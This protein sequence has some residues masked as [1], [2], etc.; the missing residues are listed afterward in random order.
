MKKLL[1]AFVISLCFVCIFGFITTE[2]LAEEADYVYI[3]KA[4]D[5]LPTA[6]E[7]TAM[8]DSSKQH[9]Y[10]EAQSIADLYENLSA[11]EVELVNA[12]KLFTLMELFAQAVEPTGV[13]SYGFLFDQTLVTSE[14][15][16]GRGWSYD[17][18]TS[19]LTLGDERG[20]PI[21]FGNVPEN[22]DNIWKTQWKKLDIS[23]LETNEFELG[24][25]A[26]IQPQVV[27][28]LDHENE[29]WEFSS[30]KPK[31]L[32]IEIK[33]TVSLGSEAWI[34]NFAVYS[35]DCKQYF[36]MGG[37]I[38]D[39]ELEIKGNGTLKIYS[40]TY[41]IFNNSIKKGT[42]INGIN[43]IAESYNNVITNNQWLYINDSTVNIKMHSAGSVCEDFKRKDV[44]GK[45]LNI[46]DSTS[47]VT[48]SS[49]YSGLSIKNSDVKIE[50]IWN[51]TICPEK[52]QY[53]T[54]L[55]IPRIYVTNSNLNVF[56]YVDGD[57]QGGNQPY[58]GAISGTIELYND[59]FVNSI[60]DTKTTL[61]NRTKLKDATFYGIDGKCVGCGTATLI[62]EGNIDAGLR[63]QGIMWFTWDEDSN[64]WNNDEVFT[65]LGVNMSIFA[66]Y[67]LDYKDSRVII[68][69]RAINTLYL[70]E[71]NG[72]KQASWNN[73]FNSCVD[74][75]D[76]VIDESISAVT[77]ENPCNIRVLSGDF[78]FIPRA[79]NTVTQFYESIGGHLTVQLKDGVNYGDISVITDPS[80]SVTIQ[81]NG[82]VE[83]LYAKPRIR[84]NQYTYFL[85]AGT[86]SFGGGTIKNCVIDESYRN[87]VF[88]NGGN[89][90]VTDLNEEYYRR[91]VFDFNDVQGTVDFMDG[92][93]SVNIKHNFEGA[94]LIDGKYY[95]IENSTVSNDELINY[96]YVKP[97]EGYKYYMVPKLVSSTTLDKIYKF[98]RV[99]ETVNFIKDEFHVYAY[100]E[101][102]DSVKLDAG[103]LQSH[104]HIPPSSIGSFFGISYDIPE[105]ITKTPPTGIYAKWIYT[106]I[107]SGKVVD[108]DESSL[109]YTIEALSLEDEFRTYSCSIYR[110]SLN[111]DVL[112]GRYDVETRV[113]V[114]GVKSQS[115][116]VKAG[117][118]VKLNLI[119]DTNDRNGWRSLYAVDWQV[120]KDNGA[121]WEFMTSLDGTVEY[122]LHFDS[123]NAISYQYRAFLHDYI[124]PFDR[125]GLH[126]YYSDVIIFT[127][128]NA[129]TF[130]GTIS[131]QTGLS[132]ETITYYVGV[133]DGYLLSVEIYWEYSMDNGKNWLIVDNNSIFS[134][135][136]LTI[137]QN[138]V[139]G[140][141][142]EY[143]TLSTFLNIN[144]KNSL[145][146]AKVRGVIH[147]KLDDS[148]QYSNE[149]EISVTKLPEISI[150][151]ENVDVSDSVEKVTLPCKIDIPE[152]GPLVD[153]IQQWQIKNDS[154]WVDLTGESNDELLLSNLKEA[155]QTSNYRCKITI[156]YNDGSHADIVRY[157]K[158]VT[159]N[160]LHAPVIENC[161]IS[162]QFIISGDTVN[163]S[164]SLTPNAVYP[165]S[166]QWERSVDRENWTALGDAKLDTAVD[167]DKLITNTI[168]EAGR[169]FIR[170]NVTLTI[171]ETSVSTYSKAVA[172]YV[173]STPVIVSNPDHFTVSNE[174][175]AT[176][177]IESSCPE[178]ISVSYHWQWKR[179]VKEWGNSYSEYFEAFDQKSLKIEG[180]AVEFES[181]RCVV[182]YTHKGLDKSYTLESNELTRTYLAKPKFLNSSKPEDARMWAGNPCELE[183]TIIMAE[184]ITLQW[185]V[186]KDNGENW[187]N[188]GNIVHYDD[189]NLYVHRIDSVT[190]EM[191]GWQF[192][193]VAT[194]TING[195]S[196]TDI[197]SVATLTVDSGYVSNYL[198]LKKA[199]LEGMTEYKLLENIAIS[200]T[201][202]VET[203]TIFDLN[204]HILSYEG[205]NC[206]S[207]FRVLN[208]AVLTI[209]DSDPTAIHDNIDI[210]GGIITG[211]DGSSI[212]TIGDHNYGGGILV[213]NGSLNYNG[214]TIYNCSA[215]LGGGIYSNGCVIKLSGG[216]LINNRA[217]LGGGIY[218]NGGSVVLSD[219][220]L[221]SDCTA[222]GEVD[223]DA[224]YVVGSAI[225][226]NGGKVSGSIYFDTA[227]TKGPGLNTTTIFEGT[228]NASDSAVIL[229]GFY[230]HLPENIS[231]YG[232]TITFIN[233]G[234]HYLTLVLASAESS[235]EPIKPNDSRVLYGW[236]KADERF[237]FGSVIT[238][239][240][241]L[242]AK[243]VFDQQTV[244]DLNNKLEDAN[245][246]LD[247]TKSELEDTKK[248]LDEAKSDLN[249]TQ[250]ELDKA[251]TDLESTK[252][253]L[254]STKLNLD[255]TK[256]ELAD[257]K[258]ELESTKSELAETKSDL[259]N[260][261]SELNNTKNELDGSKS[262]LKDT[263][264]KLENTN[265]ELNET[266]D[267]L[268]S[269]KNDLEAMR[270]E[271]EAA[272]NEISALN[273]RGLG[274][275]EIVILVFSI[276][277]ILGCG[278]VVALVLIKRKKQA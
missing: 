109:V 167:Y 144:L 110:K 183:I 192:R 223:S 177:S 238:E 258:K 137:S 103:Y 257:T 261:M 36:E 171:N 124:K 77:N 44:S 32:T 25:A 78:I 221:I 64:S 230:S 152:D 209:N 187:E 70:R 166:I 212:V 59:A 229:G 57:W 133:N 7:Y 71:E 45:S 193:C 234:M 65:D 235:F 73:E 181:Y 200:E 35:Y 120:S 55:S 218:S 203:D 80:G 227:I 79:D 277:A 153:Y 162:E 101:V 122:A 63:H 10:D 256:S 275:G 164:I 123:R 141:S 88:Y 75:E 259:D 172:L 265:S 37:I 190:G 194:N 40:S 60:A 84:G 22:T 56:A 145:D 74:L 228:I 69:Y 38:W 237:I 199:I 112:L 253:E 81:G 252:D 211:G 41:A 240:I 158:E 66:P 270:L 150:G 163:Y 76:N 170:A 105:T 54:A 159:V 207:L 239:N 260:T 34:K 262:D 3:Q 201:I 249:D 210:L 48:G 272:K 93:I 215:T 85:E 132:G 135:G 149:A 42:T 61:N 198:D 160:V 189:E 129:S 278:L 30:D 26:V 2:A 21:M 128:R 43:L 154:N 134:I 82:I 115:N 255:S 58:L 178:D 130:N 267:D 53:V 146:G 213:E 219:D 12:D 90:S 113:L 143:Q 251:K 83:N 67:S 16:S 108:L 245:N 99:E 236:L 165:Y 125:Q 9:L 246:E 18:D 208:G 102:G 191:N 13:I 138:I 202:D 87:N 126:D 92:G 174:H 243:W 95:F 29:Y 23:S 11:D 225:I 233:N 273:D 263:Q 31:K 175:S 184:S 114:F 231:R 222:S 185:Q 62:A 147:D 118:T 250:S 248:E 176:L 204:G 24:Y 197:S 179:G 155:P 4:I 5:N 131:S 142:V 68:E 182:T 6:E 107:K 156:K 14:N 247:N 72:K 89:V 220:V 232:H 136:H 98:E 106:D 127:E 47:A 86:L 157:S 206:G 139:G 33:G 111:G 186:S 27:T 216:A 196:L 8:D 151:P 269:T 46:Y 119:I 49:N 17:P 28:P 266:K 97:L 169:Y 217:T 39:G 276:V 214:G 100:G 268:N 244:D 188:I 254:D 51:R 148:Y 121:T 1:F 173:V 205:A 168:T 180:D 91:S 52:S 15:L 241:T 226:A 104:V 116:L 96:I 161:D 94:Q 20:L 19:T 50:A 195:L 140:G 271:L 117:D 242:T 224:M 264:E 274:A